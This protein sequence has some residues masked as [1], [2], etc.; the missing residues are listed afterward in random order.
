MFLPF[1]GSN[2]RRL[3]YLSKYNQISNLP[4]KCNKEVY[5]FA[6]SRDPP[7]IYTF[8]YRNELLVLCM[9]ICYYPVW[10][11]HRTFEEY[12]CLTRDPSLPG[13]YPVAH[14]IN[15][16]I[17]KRIFWVKEN[18]P[19]KMKQNSALFVPQSFRGR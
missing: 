11:P 3:H 2:S 15:F 7:D 19:K 16:L 18:M 12:L 8:P 17:F 1:L 13:G 6:Q 9:F 14:Y 5:L 4:E 10:F